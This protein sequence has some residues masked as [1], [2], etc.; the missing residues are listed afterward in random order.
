MN[1]GDPATSDDL[2]G[3]L[4]ALDEVDAD[5]RAL[6]RQLAEDPDLAGEHEPR[7][8]DLHA[9][10][11]DL[12]QQVGLV[13][14]ARRRA[15]AKLD[16]HQPASTPA[17]VAAASPTTDA[18]GLTNVREPEPAPPS[19]ESAPPS[20]PPASDAQLAQWK[21]KIRS[22]GLGVRLNDAPSAATAWPLV[23]HDL[24][25]TLGPPRVLDTT[26]DVIEETEALDA[27]GMPARQAQWAR[28]PRNAQQAWLSVLVARTRALKE[29]PPAS[30][31][32]KAKVKEIIGRYPP[33]AKEHS[34]GHVNGMQVKHSPMHGSW[35]EDARASWTILNELLSDELGT[36]LPAA[37]RKKAKRAGHDQVDEPDVDL[38]WRLLPLVRG[39]HA[40]VLGGDPREPN[41]E[42][43]ERAFQFASLEWPAIDGP[44]KVDSVVSRINKGTYGLVLVL[45]PFVAHME[46]EPIIEAAK[47]TGTPWALVEGYG[48]QAVKL[49]LERFLGGPRSGVSLAEDNDA[50]RAQRG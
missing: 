37:A 4:R 16:E 38:A 9:R 13:T 6:Y 40:I 31:S 18:N 15:S 45:Q 22:T 46:S 8:K 24:M 47:A 5:L 2:E 26:V 50:E 12:A 33:W 25:G 42:R 1:P 41:R 7:L 34:P 14:L 36:P 30:D 3:P 29:L 43:L 20:A 23:L 35:V 10:R 17:G 48:V 49:G 44:R 21:S 19:E 11:L 28:L 39:H 27:V 32:T